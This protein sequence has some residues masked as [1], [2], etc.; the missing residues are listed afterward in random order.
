MNNGGLEGLPKD[1]MPWP[2]VGESTQAAL[3]ASDI[4]NMARTP[5][6]GPSQTSLGITDPNTMRKNLQQIHASS[7]GSEDA[8]INFVYDTSCALDGVATLTEQKNSSTVYNLLGAMISN[9]RSIHT[10][11]A[12]EFVRSLKKAKTLEIAEKIND[13][14]R[15]EWETLKPN[16]KP[17]DAIEVSVNEVLMSA[18]RRK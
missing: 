7:R 18:L 5:L 10:I 6:A 11:S 2:E 3:P 16:A 13:L 4:T 17:K 9:Q 1:L 8:R 15:Q 14:Q 12:K